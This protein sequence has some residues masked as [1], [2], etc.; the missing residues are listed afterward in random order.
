MV[1]ISTF[2]LEKPVNETSDDQ[3][4]F[5][6]IYITYGILKVHL[7]VVLSLTRQNYGINYI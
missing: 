6:V 5:L 4:K 2:W 7:S 3:S 1:Y